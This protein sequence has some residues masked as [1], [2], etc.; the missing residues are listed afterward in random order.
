MSANPHTKLDE[1]HIGN[2]FTLTAISGDAACVA[3]ECTTNNIVLMNH[4][5]YCKL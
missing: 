4:D 1:R 5:I 3:S 2:T